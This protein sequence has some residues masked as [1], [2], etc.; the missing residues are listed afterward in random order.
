MVEALGAVEAT[1]ESEL[2]VTAVEDAELLLV[3]VSLV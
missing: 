3:N 2:H 1:G